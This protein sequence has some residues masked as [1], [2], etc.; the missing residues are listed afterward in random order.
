MPSKMVVVLCERG[1]LNTLF[2]QFSNILPQDPFYILKIIETPP[3]KNACVYV[4]YI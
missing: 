4:G 2:V 3:P 1:E